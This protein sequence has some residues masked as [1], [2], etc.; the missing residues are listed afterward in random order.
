MKTTKGLPLMEFRDWHFLGQDVTMC[1]LTNGERFR[2]VSTFNRAY[3]AEF[4]G[5][6]QRWK[7]AMSEW[8]R[9][10]LEELTGNECKMV[11]LTSDRN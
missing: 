3:E 10:L 9:V 2:L 5:T 7:D 1:T 4:P 6:L 8:Y 11:K